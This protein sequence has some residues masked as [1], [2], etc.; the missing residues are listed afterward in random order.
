MTP[1][2]SNKRYALIHVPKTGGT[3]FDYIFK[4]T[5][6]YF[7]PKSSILTET[8]TYSSPEFYYNAKNISFDYISG[9]LPL[10][11]VKQNV[12]NDIISIIRNPLDVLASMY[13]YNNRYPS[14]IDGE[15]DYSKSIFKR[16]YSKNFDFNRFYN[17]RLA[18]GASSFD[19]YCIQDE[20]DDDLQNLQEINVIIDFN[21][22]NESLKS[23]IEREGL[24]PFSEIPTSRK[25]N[26][27]KR[28][29][30]EFA[31]QHINAFDVKYYDNI[32]RS[33][34]LFTS[35]KSDYHSYRFNFANKFGFE[36]LSG[37]SSEYSIDKP[38]GLGWYD[39]ETDGGGKLLRRWSEPNSTIE[40]PLKNP[41]H[42]RIVVLI[43][44][45]DKGL[46]VIPVESNNLTIISNS[47]TAEGYFQCL[48]IE[49]SCV[50]SCWIDVA[51]V[52]EPMVKI[53]SLDLRDLGVVLFSVKIFRI[54]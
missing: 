21:K 43:K 30:K 1:F 52:C 37:E 26:Y 8:Q 24:Y 49:F 7:Y 25:Y 5:F 39:A 28:R 48:T 41:G 6:K 14:L 18:G 44:N 38:M 34:L 29:A 3:T 20:F 15:F 36:M 46:R 40:L 22:F 35:T 53:N 23:Y 4:N 32:I 47:S 31:S 50:D 45:I 9:H 11:L 17:D 33:S 10:S 51:I 12:Y 27:D 16:Y 2:L 42:Y 19:D 54:E 13:S